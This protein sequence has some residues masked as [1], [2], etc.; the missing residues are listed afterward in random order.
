MGGRTGLWPAGRVTTAASGHLV[1]TSPGILKQ[2]RGPVCF[3]GG[4]WCR[5]AP[6]SPPSQAS[7]CL[8]VEWGRP[9]ALRPGKRFCGPDGVSSCPSSSPHGPQA[10]AGCRSKGLTAR[11]PPAC[12]MCLC[13]GIRVDEGAL[14]PQGCLREG[15]GAP[16]GPISRLAFPSPGGPLLDPGRLGAIPSTPGRRGRAPRCGVWVPTVQGW[17]AWGGA[18][19]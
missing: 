17:G 3:W 12:F 10:I 18:G 19:F 8:A 15:A 14:G 11:A 16:R 1:P 13:S 7:A 5:A 4:P 2:A 9:G 6:E